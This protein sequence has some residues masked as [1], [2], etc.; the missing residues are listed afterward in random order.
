MLRQE[1]EFLTSNT[2]VD[3]PFTDRVADPTNA[4]GDYFSELVV[5]AYLAYVPGEV[6]K[7][8]KLTD[9]SEPTGSVVECTFKYSDN[10][11]AFTSTSGIARVFGSW[12]I[13]EWVE[14][15]GVARILV[16][17]AKIST[18]SWPVAPVDAYLVSHILQEVMPSVE[19][20]TAVPDLLSSYSLTGIVELEAGYNVEMTA[21]DVDSVRGTKRINISAVPGAGAGKVPGCDVSDIGIFTIN[22]QSPDL[23]GNIN[24]IGDDCYKLE[25]PLDL[26]DVGGEWPVIPNSLEFSNQCE[27]CCQCEDYVYLYDTLLRGSHTIGSDLS[28]TVYAVIDEYKDLREQILLEKSRRESLSLELRTT[29]RHGWTTTV[30]VI[31]YNNT[32]SNVSNIDLGV[33]FSSAATGQVIEGSAVLYNDQQQNQLVSLGGSYPSL[34]LS[35][36]LS[37]RFTKLLVLSFEVYY[38]AEIGGVANPRSA[39]SAIGVSA[40][41]VIGSTPVSGVTATTH[42][43]APFNKE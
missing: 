28:T 10:T 23:N 43:L 13:V 6:S 36:G 30:Q 14:T 3:Y 7:D 37:I 35:T 34:S 42:M 29:S 17:T 25:Y 22:G 41:G 9:L 16:E 8:V 21:E 26:T 11:T 39:G 40:T 15:T 38:P 19:A 18:F 2:S 5:D 4:D 24:L 31:V 20:I 1:M 27:P 32:D 33:S 12:T